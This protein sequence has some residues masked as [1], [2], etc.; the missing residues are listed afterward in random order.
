[1]KCLGGL[2]DKGLDAGFERYRN[3][4]VEM[5][6]TGKAKRLKNLP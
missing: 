5:V 2:N 6:S 3:A 4:D 1:M